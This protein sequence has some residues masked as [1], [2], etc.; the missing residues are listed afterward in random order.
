LCGRF[1]FSNITAE[2]QK[3]KMKNGVFPAISQGFSQLR[4][5]NEN[6]NSSLRN[7]PKMQEPGAWPGSF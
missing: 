6:E 4:E 7:S 3:A 2:V 5:W 1:S